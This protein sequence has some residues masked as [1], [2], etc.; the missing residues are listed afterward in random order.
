MHSLHPSHCVSQ[1]RLNGI[2]FQSTCTESG[3]PRSEL[4][5]IIIPVTDISLLLI[6][7]VGLFR[8]RSGGIGLVGLARVL[9]RQVILVLLSHGS[10]NPLIFF[11]SPLEGDPLASACHSG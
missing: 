10:F 9:W 8:L 7:L 3:L 5:L 11:F 4:N 6:M 2:H 1:L